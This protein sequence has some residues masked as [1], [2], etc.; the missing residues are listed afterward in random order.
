MGIEVEVKRFLAKSDDGKYYT[1]IEYQ[2]Y[3]STATLEN[4]HGEI[5]GFKR[6]VTSTGLQVNFIDAETFKIVETN[7]TLRKLV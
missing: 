2:S 6:L 5:A 7:E 3:T 4:P 1:I